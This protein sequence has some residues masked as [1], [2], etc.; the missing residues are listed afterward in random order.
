MCANGTAQKMKFSVKDFYSS[1]MEN[2][3]FYAVSEAVLTILQA[4]YNL[5]R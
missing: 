5:T 4:F 3:I 2:F 1:L